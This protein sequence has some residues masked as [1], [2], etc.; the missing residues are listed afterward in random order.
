MDSAIKIDKLKLGYENKI[1]IDELSTCVEKGIITTIIG[2]N[3]AGKSTLLKSFGKLLKAKSGNVYL[4]SKNL[5]KLS[6]KE[7][8]KHV[9][10]LLQHNVCPN[11]LTVE[12]LIHIG[13]IPHKKWYEATNSK[14]IDIVNQSMIDADIISMK[15]K[16]ISQLSGGER[17]RVWLAMALAQETDILLLDEPTTYL[18]IAYQIDMLEII[19]K[20]NIRKGI[21]IIMVLHDLN[22]AFK[23]SD[24]L[25]LIKNGKIIDKGRPQNIVSIEML[26]NIYNIDASIIEVDGSPYIIPR[27]WR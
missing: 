14:D 11:D 6:Q 17:Q 2:P 24:E 4:M 3:G 18:D 27:K 26:R 25:L 15:D 20:I 22:Q 10:I 23:Y 8:A 12:K 1:I 19:K 9:A 13:R 7:V 16:K 5:S 21:T